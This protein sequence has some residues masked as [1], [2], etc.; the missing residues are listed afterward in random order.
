MKWA[1]WFLVLGVLAVG[2]YVGQRSWGQ[3]GETAESTTWQTEPVRRG[4]LRPQIAATGTVYPRRSTVLVWQTSGRVATIVA[5]GDE[6]RA[7]QVLAR[8]AEDTWPQSLLSARAQLLDLREQRARLEVVGLAQAW[9][10]YAEAR[11]Q[12]D[13]AEKNL[14]S[15]YDQIA[16]G[17][18]V[19]EVTL[20]R[21]ESLK[22]LAE[23][24]R[25]YAAE[26]YQRWQEG[27]PPE[28]QRLDAQIQAL[29]AA[30]ATAVLTAPFDG[31][32]TQVWTEAQTWVQPGMQALRIDDLTQRYV[33]ADINEFDAPWVRAGLAARLSFDGLPYETFTGT[34]ERVAPVGEVDPQS[35][36]TQFRVRIRLDT[37]D[38]RV[39]P[40][41]TAAVTIEGDPVE[42]VL[43]VPNRAVR[44]VEGRPTVYVLRAGEL[45]PVPVKLGVTSDVYSQVLEGDLQDGDRVVLN[46][47]TP[48]AFGP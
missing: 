2:L 6:V 1:R 21:Y 24:Q 42:D 32:V 16:D 44:V 48:S 9:N 46:P 12:E 40:G 30:L 45:V 39:R 5:V 17:E 18:A 25:R 13:R 14:Q 10:Q 15:L 41:M 47:P 35:G 37:D 7:G 26:V 43:L 4:T 19:S 27:N 8:L 23:A 22:A 33:E 34:V 29:E 3:P 36:L 28:L 38:P 20:E 11:Y 31:T